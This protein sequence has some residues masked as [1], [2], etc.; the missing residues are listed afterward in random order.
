MQKIIPK[1]GN[2]LDKGKETRL[3]FEV[4]NENENFIVIKPDNEVIQMYHSQHLNEL[5]TEKAINNEHIVLDFSKVRYLDSTI[6]GTLFTQSKK[7]SEKGL[8][9][10]IIHVKQALKLL[11]KVTKS[12][13][14]LN[15]YNSLGDML[16]SVKWL[17]KK[18]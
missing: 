11:F 14:F 18:V 5:I 8:V 13:S 10:S 4:N 6:M 3:K 7:L 15:I 12:Y 9:L 1:K 17:P 16:N 2:S